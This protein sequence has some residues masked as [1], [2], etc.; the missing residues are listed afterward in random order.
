[1]VE[2]LLS[3]CFRSRCRTPLFFPLSLTAFPIAR[4]GASP[5]TP[6]LKERGVTPNFIRQLLT[7]FRTSPFRTSFRSRCRSLLFFP[8]SL[9]AFPIARSGASPPTPLLKER[10]VTPNF[11]RQLLTHFRT[12]P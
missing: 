1:M 6:L 8:L 7:H 5:P 2:Q 10:G 9:T 3:N 12:S 11:I 4:S